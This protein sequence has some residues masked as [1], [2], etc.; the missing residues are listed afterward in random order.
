MVILHDRCQRAKVPSGGLNK[1]FCKPRWEISSFEEEGLDLFL[2]IYLPKY[3][4]AERRESGH[5]ILSL[6]RQ[7]HS[8]TIDIRVKLTLANLPNHPSTRQYIAPASEGLPELIG[9]F[10]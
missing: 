3:P 6:A 5:T 1:S 2:L 8:P 9:I 4:V 7:M 10:W